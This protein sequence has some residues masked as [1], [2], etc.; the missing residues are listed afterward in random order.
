[1]ASRLSA[2]SYRRRTMIAM[3]IYVVLLLLVWPLARDADTQWLKIVCALTPVIPVLYV[4]ALMTRKVL[5]SDELE[6][7]THLIGLGVATAVVSVYSLIGGFLAAAKVLP[8]NTAAVL[9]LWVF[10][11]LV[12]AYS[13]VRGWVARRY[14]G[15][16][17]GDESAT[18]Y[19]RFLMPAVL[20]G[21]VAVYA[22]FVKHDD[23][24]AGIAAGMASVFILVVLFLGWR[25]WAKRKRVQ[26]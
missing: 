3:S 25:Q 23:Y 24:L 18:S 21:V 26:E 12:V 19:T 13:S 2:K 20:I 5:H 7:R 6:Q 1:M 4:I 16:A 10:P 9:L 14:G 8:P 11:L 17:C 15:D 22:E